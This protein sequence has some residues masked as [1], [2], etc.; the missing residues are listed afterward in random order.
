MV[1]MPVA[2]HPRDSADEC[3]RSQS[4]V[5][6]CGIEHVR[7]GLRRAGTY[8]MRS[9]ESVT[10]TASAL[11]STACFSRSICS[12]RAARRCGG[13]SPR[14]QR[15]GQKGQHPTEPVPGYQGPLPCHSPAWVAPP[16]CVR[17]ANTRVVVWLDWGHV[18]PALG[19]LGPL[20]EPMSV[21]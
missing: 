1:L 9:V 20:A 17:L 6:R 15:L 4:R 14:R 3:R 5:L 21:R 12:R 13:S 19:E 18:K 8:S 7:H 16:I 10:H 11:C 2:T